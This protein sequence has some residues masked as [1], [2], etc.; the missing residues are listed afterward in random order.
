L[1]EWPLGSAAVSPCGLGWRLLGKR[2][3]WLLPTA[4]ALA[5][6][7]IRGHGLSTPVWA[8]PRL[9]LFGCGRA[10]PWRPISHRAFPDQQGP[11]YTLPWQRHGVVR[12]GINNRTKRKNLMNRTRRRA[13]LGPMKRRT[14]VRGFAGPH[15]SPGNSRDAAGAGVTGSSPTISP[16]MT[17]QRRSGLNRFATR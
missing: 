15:S 7:S 1:G 5:I 2:A 11:R 6:T 17:C 9:A 10:G 12:I 13:S 3:S 8:D 4:G 16:C 14:C